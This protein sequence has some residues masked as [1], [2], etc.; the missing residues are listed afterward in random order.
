MKSLV[1]AAFVCALALGS[2]RQEDCHDFEVSLVY[3]V[4]FSLKTDNPQRK[5][6]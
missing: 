1:A 6:G 5:G 4:K 2:L 3:K